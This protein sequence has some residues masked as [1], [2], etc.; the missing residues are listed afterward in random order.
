MKKGPAVKHAIEPHSIRHVYSGERDP[1]EALIRWLM[2]KNYWFEVSRESGGDDA[3]YTLTCGVDHDTVQHLA[4]GVG[5][6]VTA[7]D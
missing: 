1:I 6:V 4:H 2:D 3:G 5:V 7:T